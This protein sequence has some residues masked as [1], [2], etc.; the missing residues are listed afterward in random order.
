MN[1][2]IREGCADTEIIINCPVETEEIR[3]TA[4][5]L[6][7]DIQKLPGIKDGRTYLIDRRE[8]MYVESVDKRCF[9]YT[10]DA[11]YE[12]PL[13]LYEIEARTAGLGFFRSAKSQIVNL[14][15]IKSLRP[16]FGGRLEVVMETGERLIVS[17]Q[18]A[19]SLK[20]RMGLR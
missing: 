12:T 3:Q 16:D 9:I 5:M 11:T 14:T 15:R 7:G 19:K 1:V 4:D 6:R 10:T 13:K 18:Y 17:R 8:V 2:I 20:E